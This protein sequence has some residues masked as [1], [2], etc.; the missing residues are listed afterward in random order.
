MMVRGCEQGDFVQ[1]CLTDEFATQLP[2]GIAAL[3]AL[4]LI[5]IPIGIFGVLLWMVGLY[6]A[7]IVVGNFVGVRLLDSGGESPHFTV[8]LAVGLALVIIAVNLPLVGGVINFLLTILGL[9]LL[10]VY[11][12]GARW[13]VPTA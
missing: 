5:G 8:P 9:G 12:Y 13:R 4:T 11:L 2:A 1:A 7:K 10:V 6:L 3:V